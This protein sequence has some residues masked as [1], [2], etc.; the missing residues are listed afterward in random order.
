MV[1]R[2]IRLHDV[3]LYSLRFELTLLFAH[4][5]AETPFYS[6]FDV[7]PYWAKKAIYGDDDFN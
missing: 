5:N 7:V 2:V 4:F 6:C 3:V 1:V